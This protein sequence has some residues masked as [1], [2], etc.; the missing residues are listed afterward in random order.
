MNRF[1]EIFTEIT[2][3]F[4]NQSYRFLDTSLPLFVYIIFSNLFDNIASFII[5]T[6]LSIFLLILRLLIKQK[7][8]FIISGFSLV[9]LFFFVSQLSINNRSILLPSIITGFFIITSCLGSIL[10]GKPIA[11]F[12]SSLTRKWP[13]E[14]YWHPN[15]K[16]AY[17]DVTLFWLIAFGGRSLV[18]IITY[19]NQL[20]NFEWFKLLFGWPYTIIV[21]IISYLFGKWRLEKLKGPSVEEFKQNSPPPWQGQKQGF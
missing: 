13:L 4:A 12:S 10:I 21:L 5:V 15:I 7:V 11:A 18:E 17:R 20:I 2:S 6:I 19:E 14:W 3:I 1:E 9:A 8:T 16:P